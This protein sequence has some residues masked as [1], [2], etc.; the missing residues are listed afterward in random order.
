MPENINAPVSADNE[1]VDFVEYL[2]V[3]ARRKMLIFKVSG[4][5]FILSVVLAVVLPKIYAAT[6]RILP[7][8]QDKGIM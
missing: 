1:E 7:P 5:A 4:A 3:V 2:E 8:Q 6:A